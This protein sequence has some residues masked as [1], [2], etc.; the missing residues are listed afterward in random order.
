MK[1]RCADSCKT[2]VNGQKTF[3]SAQ[4]A[5][6]DKQ[7]QRVAYWQTISTVEPEN[8][9]FLDEMGVLQGMSRPREEA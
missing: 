2:A 5:A 9:V 7:T 8:L 3:R 4:A 6:A 1:V